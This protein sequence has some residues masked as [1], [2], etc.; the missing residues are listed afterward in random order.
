[1]LDR[2]AAVTSGLRPYRVLRGTQRCT[3]C[4]AADAEQRPIGVDHS[5]GADDVAGWAH[6]RRR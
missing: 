3:A 5:P 4:S 6:S 1:M 2:H